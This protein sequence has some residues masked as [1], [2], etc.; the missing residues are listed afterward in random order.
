MT[1][2]R[3]S[4]VTTHPLLPRKV[5]FDWSATRAHWIPGDPFST[6]FV[7]VIH[8][9]S[10]AFEQWFCHVFRQTLPAL[11]DAALKAAVK[12][13]IAQEGTHARAHDS[14]L[15][16]M[17]LQGIDVR[18]FTRAIEWL[19]GRLLADAPL[20]MR[21][22]TPALERFWLRV[23]VAIIAGLEHIT[24]VL[25]NWSLNADFE[26]IDADPTM[27]DLLRWHG[28]EEVEHRT[29][30]ADVLDAMGG[31]YLLRITTMLL[32]VVPGFFALWFGGTRFL[33]RRDPHLVPSAWTWRAI[34]RNF[35][36]AGEQ[37]RLPSFRY[38]IGSFA[39]YLVPYHDAGREGSTRQAVAYLSRSPAAVAAMQ[40][41]NAS[42]SRN[43]EH[44]E[45]A[46]RIR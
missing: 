33:T 23:R 39:R 28:A 42:R 1:A 44:H 16:H 21:W 25:G 13:F 43:R 46:S 30:A 32:L 5:R 45:D 36:R 40:A 34:F 2:A 7:N 41:A 26:S 9:L 8:L 27:V 37:E 12:G 38:L 22:R 11:D 4:D 18:P 14:A 35:R 6:H 15:T 3:M 29:V 19:C 20:G 17:E 24:C 10:P 31:H